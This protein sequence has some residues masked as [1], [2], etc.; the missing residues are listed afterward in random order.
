[1]GLSQV[2][3]S[4]INNMNVNDECI[5]TNNLDDEGFLFV[6]VCLNLNGHSMF[7]CLSGRYWIKDFAVITICNLHEHNLTAYKSI[8]QTMRQ[9]WCCNPK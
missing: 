7:S 8:L 6:I 2:M 5:C 9:T 3:G 4:S 1:M